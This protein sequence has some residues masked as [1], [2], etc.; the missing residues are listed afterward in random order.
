MQI[1]V[2]GTGC[3]RCKAV[4]KATYDALA[5]LGVD[6][7]VAKVTDI[8]KIVEYVMATPGLV[9]NEKVKSSGRVPA[10]EEI[11]KWISEELAG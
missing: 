10:K 7:S 8:D 3:P 11:K 6:A 4:E 1:K 5:E 9:I 2:L